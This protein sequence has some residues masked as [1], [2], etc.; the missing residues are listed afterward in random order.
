[1]TDIQPIDKLPHEMGRR[2][3]A[4]ALGSVAILGTDSPVGAQ[5]ASS[6]AASAGN[7]GAAIGPTMNEWLDL[8][9]GGK[10]F[11]APL[12][13]SRFLDRTYYLI[14]DLVWTATGESASLGKIT[15]PAGFVTD[16]ASVPRAFWAYLP[17]DDDYVTAA[18]IHD[19]LYWTQL[20]TRGQADQALKDCM[21]ELGVH[22]VK[23]AAIY[24]GV[25]LFGSFAWNQNAS[26]KTKG[27]RRVLKETPQD[28]KVRW[29]DWK[30][31]PGVFQ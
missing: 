27:E 5:T 11:G 22:S 24:Q 29:A 2:R 17:P 23:V 10:G 25:N 6:E 4:I 13:V 30:L 28:L 3:F 12:V 1:M 15:A 26:L 18:V 19:W 7:N 8:Y 31:K 9:F 21:V 20:T 16:F 14:R